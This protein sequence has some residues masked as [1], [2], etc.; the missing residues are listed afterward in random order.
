VKRLDNVLRT[1]ACLT[2]TIAAQASAQDCFEW[3][4]R[5]DVTEAPS[6]RYS[7]AIAYDPVSELS[8]LFGGR[9][10]VIDLG[11]TWAW[12]GDT[13]TLLDPGDPDGISAPAPRREAVM[14][15]DT[16]RGRLVLFGGSE[17]INGVDELLNDTWEWIDDG[18]VQVEPGGPGGTI[19]PYTADA[20]GFDPVCGQLI[21]YGGYDHGLNRDETWGWDG[22]TWQLLVQGVPPG[23]HET[24]IAFKR[25]GNAV[26]FGGATGSPYDDTWRWECGGW[27]QLQVSGPSARSGHRM[28]YH[29]EVGVTLLFG[30]YSQGM[31]NDLWAWDGSAWANLTPSYGPS[32]RRNGAMVYHASTSTAML[33]G[34]SDGTPTNDT[35]EY[36]RPL[37]PVD[38]NQDCQVNSTDI[39]WFLNRFAAGEPSADYNEDGAVDSR[40]FVMF[41]NDFVAGCYR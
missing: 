26:L 38:L 1:V 17:V 18:W 40:D 19:R 11:D 15:Y 35:W 25:D 8:V 31:R 34:G 10:G 32:P 21:A 33:F 39:V 6:P 22:I 5:S 12:D 28:A 14:G 36:G 13:W 30:G 9:N 29:E 4:L 37:C 16:N 20:G 3:W 23:R 7:A 24:D 41:L 2:A 27:T